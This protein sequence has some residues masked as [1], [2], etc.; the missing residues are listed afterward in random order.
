VDASHHPH[1]TPKDAMLIFFFFSQHQ[2]S[3]SLSAPPI[4]TT[5]GNHHLRSTPLFGIALIRILFSN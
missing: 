1:Q 4:D 3:S 2:P 5:T